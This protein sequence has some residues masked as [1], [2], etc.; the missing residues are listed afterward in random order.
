MEV[1]PVIPAGRQVIQSYGHGGFKITDRH[2]DGAVLV[3]PDRTLSWNAVTLDDLTLDEITSMLEAASV[4]ILLIGTGAKHK[5]VPGPL[6]EGFSKRRIVAESMATPAACR[7]YNVLVA[8]E[9]R[10]AAVLLPV[11]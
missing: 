4:E 10:V 7:T 9:R 6:K 11:A 8:E 2:F 5:M 3:S 1:T